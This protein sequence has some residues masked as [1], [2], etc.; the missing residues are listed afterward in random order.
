[1]HRTEADG[2]TKVGDLPQTAE[3]GPGIPQAFC[4]LLAATRCHTVKDGS[5]R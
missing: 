5:S 4:R 1:M 2:M 3:P